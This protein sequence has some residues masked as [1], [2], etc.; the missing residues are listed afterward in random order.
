MPL[1][2]PHACPRPAGD[3]ARGTFVYLLQKCCFI[4]FAGRYWFSK[5]TYV[6]TW[7]VSDDLWITCGAY[8]GV[9][10]RQT[11][12][13]IHFLSPTRVLSKRVG[14]GP[15][16]II[17][18]FYFI[19]NLSLLDKVPIW[20]TKWCL[21]GDPRHNIVMPTALCTNKSV[22]C[23]TIRLKIAQITTLCG[24]RAYMNI[25]RLRCKIRGLRVGVF[26]KM[27]NLDKFNFLQPSFVIFRVLKNQ[28]FV[29]KS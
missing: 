8:S 2:R 22:T 20:S 11:F 13:W 27:Y 15:S 23:L 17:K 1:Q 10:G 19:T 5:L 16:F 29:H 28:P 14:Y 18:S 3:A 24:N 26:T 6:S 25:M 4:S 9:R 7:L 21:R 12:T